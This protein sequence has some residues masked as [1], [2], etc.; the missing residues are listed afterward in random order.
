MSL[1]PTLT[2]PSRRYAAL[3]LS[4]CAVTTFTSLA[5]AGG[6]WG[7]HLAHASERERPSE[8]PVRI[9]SKGERKEAVPPSIG[10]TVDGQNDRASDRSSRWQP[11]VIFTP[12][13]PMSAIT[14]SNGQGTEAPGGVAGAC[15]PTVSTW[16]NA[17]FEGGSYIVQAGFAEQEMAACSYTIPA[18]AFPI[19]IDMT[20]MI[21]ATSN[22]TVT[23]TTKWSVLFFEG[24]P[25]N[26]QVV[27]SFSSDG[28]ILP[29]LVMP[30]GTNGTNIQF[31]IDPSDPEQIVIQDNGSQTFTVAYRID[32]HNNQTQNPCF[33]SPPSASNAFP[34]TDVGG[35]QA[36]TNN[37]LF[38]VNCGAFGCPAGWRRF[39]QLGLCQ[40]S[41]DWVMRVTWSSFT[42]PTQGACCLP[43]G[44]CDFLTQ[45]ECQAQG[46]TY[47]GDD[48]PCGIGACNSATVACCFQATG[49]CLNLLPATCVAAGGV[50][51]PQGSNCTGFICFPT[52][53]CCLPNGN[54]IGPVS[55]ETC[56]AQGGVF[57][58]NNTSCASANCP[59]PVGACCFSTGFCLQ[60]KEADCALAGATWQGQGTT[61]ADG[62][63]NGTADACEQ[64]NPADLNNDGFVNAGDLAILLGAWGNAGGPADINDDGTVNASDL[65]ILL[66]A[67]G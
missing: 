10:F 25:D 64:S 24:T 11:K 12:V 52:G 3:V 31:L 58:G 16:T 63:G 56:A 51:G 28:D 22:A 23:T 7:S 38:A 32:D 20:E 30:P 65:S 13:T 33:V 39:S 54:C 46:G 35:L 2:L 43:N 1:M 26:G 47:L 6:I 53:A 15:P 29:H 21:F 59:Q 61:C 40:P 50:P 55:P 18:S 44:N 45:Q 66:G 42:C 34:T 14:P 17:S 8:K 27:A 67:W 19:K 9:E 49:G 41:G 57:Q 5:F 37:W 4:A 48:V 36:A 60:L 62:N